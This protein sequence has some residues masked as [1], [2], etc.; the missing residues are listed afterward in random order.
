MQFLYNV[1]TQDKPWLCGT[2][3]V[4]RPYV[5][6]RGCGSALV[7]DLRLL[8]PAPSTDEEANGQEGEGACL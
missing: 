1:R 7:K 4:P 8:P 3:G 2:M 5:W 6:C